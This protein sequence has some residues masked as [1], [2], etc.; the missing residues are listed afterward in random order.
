MPN[1]VTSHLPFVSV[2]AKPSIPKMAY[3]AGHYWFAVFEPNM[4]SQQS[5]LINHPW[6]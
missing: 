6:K 1:M 5:L 3:M 4:L 2:K